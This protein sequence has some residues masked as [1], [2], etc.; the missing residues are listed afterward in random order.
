M[1]KKH[2]EIKTVLRERR[3]LK[4]SKCSVFYR[5]RITWDGI[6]HQFEVSSRIPVAR[7]QWDSTREQINGKDEI[8]LRYNKQIQKQK[9]SVLDAFD[10]HK[11]SHTSFNVTVFRDDV[12][13]IINPKK[14]KN[15]PTINRLVDL[16]D[17]Y[18]A[19]FG[20]KLTKKRVQRYAFIKQMLE[21]FLIQEFGHVDLTVQQIGANG[22]NF[23]FKF[24]NYLGDERGLEQATLEGY[25]KILKATTN[26]AERSGLIPFNPF[27]GCKSEA[28]K[29]TRTFLLREDVERIRNASV[30]TDSL[31]NIKWLFMLQVY[32]G[33]GH[34]DLRKL[35]ADRI[36]QYPNGRKAIV[37]DRTKTAVDYT[38]PLNE[39][40]QSI[41]EDLRHR[42]SSDKLLPVPCLEDYNRGLK[43]IRAACNIQRPV[44]SH[45]G[46]H[47]FATLWLDNGGSIEA[48][49]NILGHKSIRSTQ[50][51]GKIRAQRVLSEACEVFA[52]FLKKETP[53][54]KISD[55]KSISNGRSNEAANW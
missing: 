24:K 7:G 54:V 22:R 20:R 38:I 40:A 46:R 39:E 30:N 1:L 17:D 33:L 15:Q 18:I 25:M 42:S 5:I 6:E 55:T 23:Y 11:N 10:H 35:T 12:Y 49:S 21:K 45:V 37:D 8:S 26:E 3:K 9:I 2:L 28:L 32:T 19:K 52:T 34:G 13:R 44:T 27:T 36:K 53:V 48:L 47:T 16:F 31:Y 29:T 14:V 51:Y 43:I 41:I 4:D 50:V